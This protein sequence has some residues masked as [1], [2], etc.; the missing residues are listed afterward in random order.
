RAFFKTS[1]G[2]HGTASMAM[3]TGDIAVVL[4]GSRIPFVLRK[5]GSMYRLVSDC[6]VQGLMD[7]EALDMLRNGELES[8]KFQLR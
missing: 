7:G 2:W 8:E 5:D 6:Y 3:K 4:F 1:L